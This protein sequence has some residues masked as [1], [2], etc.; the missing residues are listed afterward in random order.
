M[1][2]PDRISKLLLSASLTCTL[3]CACDK[4]E[5][6]TKAGADEAGE[7]SEQDKQL[8]ARLAEK[9]AARDAAV[10]ADEDKAVAIAALA[11]L[12]E[13]LPKNLE[14]ACKEVAKAQDAFM[15]AH[16]EGEGLARWEE[17]KGTQMGM[18]EAGCIKAGNIE[19]AACQT[20]AMGNAPGEYKKDL[21]DLLK[22]CID[23]FGAGAAAGEAEPG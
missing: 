21:P 16:Y 11:V 22:A 1:L 19:V 23:K 10:K 6:A 15:Q 13:A 7:K 14:T 9:K 4:Q 20:H 12:P 18:L 2:H 8:E 17:A 3:L 5:D